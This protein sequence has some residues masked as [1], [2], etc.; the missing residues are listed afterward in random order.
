MASLPQSFHISIR[1]GN[2]QM[3]SVRVCTVKYFLMPAALICRAI[4]SPRFTFIQKMSS[5]MKIVRRLDLPAAR[6]TTRSGDFSRNVALV[7]LPDRAEVALERTAARGLHQRQRLA[8]VD[9]V[10]VGVVLDEM[11]RRQRIVVEVLARRRVAGAD[12]ASPS[13]CSI[14]AGNGG[15]IVAALER[16]D[17]RRH[18]FFAVADRDD[19][20]RRRR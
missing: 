20:D 16:V 18:H 8:E 4:S 7:K 10:V 6:A 15:Q 13:R 11:P 5:V 9:V 1:C 2:L 12:P 17:Q 14:E 3:M 19:V